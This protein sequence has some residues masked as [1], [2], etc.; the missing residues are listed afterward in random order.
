MPMIPP[1]GRLSLGSEKNHKIP[2][3]SLSLSTLELPCRCTGEG[4]LC[5]VFLA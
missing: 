3:F 2:L 1:V 5:V 4:M